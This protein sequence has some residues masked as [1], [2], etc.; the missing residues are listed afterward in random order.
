MQMYANGDVSGAQRKF[1]EALE[2]THDIVNKLVL[3]LKSL[4]VSF[5]IA[6]YEADA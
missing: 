3:E 6:P 4:K 5:L 2:I 1:V